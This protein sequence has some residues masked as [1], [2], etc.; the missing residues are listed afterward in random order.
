MNHEIEPALLISLVV[1][2]AMIGFIVWWYGVRKNGK[3]ESTSDVLFRAPAYEDK[4]TLINGIGPTLERKLNK[5]GITTFKQIAELTEADI[6]RVNQVLDFKGRIEREEWVTQ[7][8]TLVQA[9]SRSAAPSRDKAAKIA[10][11]T[12]KPARKTSGKKTTKKKVTKKSARK[13]TRSK[14]R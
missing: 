7:A 11:A 12:N 1:L 10:K 2:I 8:K 6:E 5:L 13:K 3:D 14:K 4:L 9:G